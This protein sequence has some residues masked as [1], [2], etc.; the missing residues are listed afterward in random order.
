VLREQ[1]VDSRTRVIGR[2]PIRAFIDAIPE[3]RDRQFVSQP[4]PTDFYPFSVDPDTVGATEVADHDLTVL[5]CQAAMATRKPERIAACVTRWVPS[6]HDHVLVDQN[7]WA[8]VEG[9]ESRGH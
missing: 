5:M 4:Q 9:H 6:H 1:V 7:V 8:P 2:S 3:V